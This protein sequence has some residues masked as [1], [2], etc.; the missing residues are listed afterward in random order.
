MEGDLA[1]LNFSVF[2]ISLVSDQTNGG[3]WT[4]FSEVLVPFGH[5]SV[6]VSVGEIKHDDSAVGVNIIAVSQFTEF[7]LSS[8]VPDV[9][10]Q[11]S[12]GGVELDV[13]YNCSLGG[14]VGFLE[15]SSGVSLR[16]GGFAD[17][18]VSDQNKFECGQVGLSVN[19][20]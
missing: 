3:I 16:E 7:F 6:R 2:D 4:N 14:D 8:C 15:M 17:S 12:M 11:R 1:C 10:N 13:G 19:H 20:N 5:V 9:E 18:S